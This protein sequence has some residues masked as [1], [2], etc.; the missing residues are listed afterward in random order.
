M[1]IG[2]RSEILRRWVAV[3]TLTAAA[4]VGSTSVAGATDL[5]EQPSESGI[6]NNFWVAHLS[7]AGMPVGSFDLVL[8]QPNPDTSNGE[9]VP[10]S[11]DAGAKTG[12]VPTSP[13]TAQLGFRN[14]AGATTAQM[15]GDTVGAYLNSADLPTKLSNQLMMIAPQYFFPSGATP[16]PFSSSGAVLNGE[17]NLQIPTAVGK[18][19]YVAADFV[20][21]AA[22]GVRVSFSVVLFHNEIPRQLPVNT[23]YDKPEDVYILQVPLYDDQ[24]FITLVQGSESATGTPWTGFRHFQWSIDQTQFVAALKYLVAKFPGKITSTDP[25]QYVLDEVHLNAEFHYSPAPAEL[26]WS[27]Q[28][29]QVWVSG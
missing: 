13:S 4:T 1:Q 27:M 5:F 12:F 11:W 25:T 24:Q 21:L 7:N 16:V 8:L 9:L 2:K 22:S 10:T 23:T 3:L 18:D 19:T 15:E 17:L 6:A 14:E 28:G 20:F 26:G 29:W